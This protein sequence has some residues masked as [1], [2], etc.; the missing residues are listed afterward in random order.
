MNLGAGHLLTLKVMRLS[1]PNYAKVLP[2]FVEADTDSLPLGKPA[3]VDEILRNSELLSASMTATDDPAA[4]GQM[5]QPSLLDMD[6]PAPIKS[7]V[8]REASDFASTELLVLPSSFGNIY[9]GETFTAYMCINNESSFNAGDVV[10]RADLQTGTQRLTLHD[11]SQESSHNLLANQTVEFVLNHEIKEL[12]MHILICTIRYTVGR[13]ERQLKKSYKFN[14]LNPL[15]VKTKI[16]SS[17]EGKFFLEAQLQNVSAAPMFLERMRFEPTEHFQVQDLNLTASEHSLLDADGD[18]TVF[19]TPYLTINEIRQYLFLITPKIPTSTTWRGF[20][21]L[22]KLD[23]AWRSSMGEPGRLQTSQLV[24]KVTV[25]DPFEVSVVS[26]T[27]TLLERPFSIILRVRNSSTSPLSLTL[28]MMKEKM[29]ALLPVGSITRFI[30][31]LQP[32]EQ[33]DTTVQ[34]FPLA[35][36]VQSVDGLCVSDSLT[37]FSKELTNMCQV[38]VTR[39]PKNKATPAPGTLSAFSSPGS[40]TISQQQQPLLNLLD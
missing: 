3:L 6:E 19:G 22:G 14:S 25:P 28:S 10:F 32:G 21:G 30:G 2:A 31:D 16:N 1:R 26:M 38:F 8:S 9:L 7:T 35:P 23:I 29:I 40:G 13:E 39:Q 17:V 12:G 20:A 15:A 34:L 27:D 11:T 5:H 18:A 33:S 24:R 4:L 37:G 36:G